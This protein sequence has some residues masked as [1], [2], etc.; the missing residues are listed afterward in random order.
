VEPPQIYDLTYLY[1]G[2]ANIDLQRY[3]RSF[4]V[5]ESAYER[6]GST[7]GGSDPYDQ[8]RDE[9]ARLLQLAGVLEEHVSQALRKVETFAG[10]LNRYIEEDVKG[11]E[12]RVLTADGVEELGAVQKAV[13]PVPSLIGA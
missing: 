7:E 12:D 2:E 11:W 5:Y 9:Q 6:V 4:H 1:F 3:W 8:A 10:R 13:Q